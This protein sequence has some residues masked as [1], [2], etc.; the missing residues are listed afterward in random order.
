[1]A[2]VTDPTTTRKPLQAFYAHLFDTSGA[3]VKV[4]GIL[5]FVG[6]DG[7]VLDVEP[8]MVNFLVVLGAVDVAESQ[9]YDDLLRGGAP[10]IATHRQQ[11]VA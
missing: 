7:S 3:L 6:D 8:S 11:E 9:R 1:M 4:G 10:W 5:T 2:T